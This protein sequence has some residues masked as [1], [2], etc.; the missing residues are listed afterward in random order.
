MAETLEGE[1]MAFDIN[2]TTDALLTALVRWL[3]EGDCMPLE[4]F[5][6]M[7]KSVLM[8]RSND[9]VSMENTKNGA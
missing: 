3:R 8:S 6:R 5:L 1:A 9:Y 2:I 4:V 7:I